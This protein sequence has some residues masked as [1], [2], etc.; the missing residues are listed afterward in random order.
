P[1][2]KHVSGGDWGMRQINEF[3]EAI[4]KPSFFGN[5]V[6]Y[7]GTA[8]WFGTVA[9]E[10]V[11]VLDAMKQDAYE[12]GIINTVHASSKAIGGWT[13]ASCGASIGAAIL[14]FI[15]DFGP[16]VGG[17]VGGYIGAITG[18][19]VGEAAAIMTVGPTPEF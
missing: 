7:I 10:S 11:F 2:F 16:L 8:L 5:M 6:C 1:I 19:V 15:P 9:I 18:R 13:G 17:I 3:G 12:G 4:Y 14:S